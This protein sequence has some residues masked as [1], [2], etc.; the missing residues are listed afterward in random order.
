MS[1]KQ[2]LLPSH[3]ARLKEL[4]TNGT[5]KSVSKSS[6]F[7]GVEITT[8]DHTI[9]KRYD[10]DS[11][12]ID[13]ELRRLLPRGLCLIYIGEVLVSALTGLQK[14]GYEG[15]YISPKKDRAV[16]WVYTRKE[17]G[18][19]GHVYAFS[20][21]DIK[22]I[23]FGSK[24]VH[25]VLRAS[26]IEDDLSL[27]MEERYKYANKIAK[28]FL[29]KHNSS[30]E[31][32]IDFCIEHNV[33]L[34]CEAIFL[35][36][37]HLVVYQEDS[38]KFF[39]ITSLIESE[40]SPITWC[41]PMIAKDHF[42]SLELDSVTEIEFTND[43]CEWEKIKEK[44]RSDFNSEGGVVYLLDKDGNV[45]F[46]F[47]FKNDMY[48]FW[49]AVREQMRKLANN[50]SLLRRLRDLHV[51]LPNS[52]E[53]TMHALQFNAFFRLKSEEEQKLFFSQWNTYMTQFM[54][55]SSEEKIALVTAY[56]Q[57]QQQNGSLTVIML[58]GIQG[59]GKSTIARLLLQ[60]L[61]LLHGLKKD[62]ILHL[63][64]DMFNGNAKQYNNAVETALTKSRLKF[65][66]LA[67]MNHKTQIRNSTSDILGKYKGNLQKVYIVL[68]PMDID[69][70][71]SRIER[72]GYAHES[73]FF[74]SK[75]VKILETTLSEY[76]PLS[77]EEEE[78]TPTLHLDI[79]DSLESMITTTFGFLKSKYFIDYVSF[80]EEQFQTSLGAVIQDDERLSKKPKKTPKIRN[81]QFDG[82]SVDLST[83][84]F[85]ILPTLK[86]KEEFH[87]TSR[88]YGRKTAGD[89]DF[90]LD[91]PCLVRILAVVQDKNAMALF[92]EVPGLVIESGL[93]HITY[94]LATGVKPVYSKKLIEEALRVSNITYL[95]T[96]I[97]IMG[98]TFRKF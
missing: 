59:S 24:N 39:G 73:L 22:Y 87:I 40:Q 35:D 62:E 32:V 55:L 74:D 48:V 78:Q 33:T 37:Q 18:E 17:N 83:T 89:P 97:E 98:V 1:T 72:R 25:M 31:R 11:L 53:I 34:T 47:K 61:V 70:H 64:Q 81:P 28:L 23:V 36:S 52:E 2:D 65:L 42:I 51:T 8:V 75:T 54:C 6:I 41:N 95:E 86:I 26:N 66:L 93:P 56:Q 10:E 79:K 88:Y 68:D 44:I 46:I 4:V 50:E 5:L 45:V 91:K 85:D 49:R 92:C 90:A 57:L 20:H 96:P 12:Y 60:L 30:L 27:Y 16:S 3:E 43:H 63:E 58:V 29:D 77:H 38:L 80:D 9:K 94:A 69:F 76:E 21:D 84:Q 13:P 71:L 67:K 19:C 7:D 14:F 82:V 15:D